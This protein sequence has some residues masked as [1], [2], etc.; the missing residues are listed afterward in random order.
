MK[1]LLIVKSGTSINDSYDGTSAL[2]EGVLGCRVVEEAGNKLLELYIG[3]ADNVPFMV[4]VYA[5]FTEVKATNS[6][7]S[8]FEATITVPEVVEGSTYTL[9]LVKLGTKFNERSN[10]TATVDVPIGSTKDAAWVAVQLANQLANK[11]D[12]AG[13]P[14]EI[15]VSDENIEIV[16][17]KYGE[18]F[19]LKGADEL[20]GLEENTPATPVIGDKAYIENLASEC[21]AGKGFTETDEDILPGYPE[22]VEAVQYNVTTLRFATHRRSAKTRDEVVSQLVHIAIPSSISTEDGYFSA[23][24]AEEGEGD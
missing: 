5:P 20:V 9:V 1:Q 10:Y 12:M 15:T 18:A 7:G 19:A 2:A 6:V 24:V 22:N 4:P 23:L 11:V 21:A 13:L 17:T 16:G 14:V 8:A 3:R